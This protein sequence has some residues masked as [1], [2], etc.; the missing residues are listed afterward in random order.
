MKEFFPKTLLSISLTCA[1]FTIA[2]A[3]FMHPAKSTGQE[4]KKQNPLP[5]IR[6]VKDGWQ[7]NPETVKKVL[8]S[9]AADLWKHF[10]KRKLPPLLVHPNKGPIVL[11]KRSDKG[12]IVVRLNTGKTYWSQYA[13]QF[14]HEFCHV[15]CEYDPDPHGNDWFEESICEL[16]SLYTLRQMGKTWKTKPPYPHWKSYAKHLTQYAADRI[17]DGQLKKGETLAK[18]FKKNSEALYASATR[19]ELNL[20][21]ATQLLPMFEAEPDHWQAVGYLNKAKPKSKQ[22]FQQ[23]LSDWFRHCP[24]RHQP[25]VKKI[26]KHFEI[27]ILKPSSNKSKSANSKSKK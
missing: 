21:V 16:A 8:E 1:F 19:R 9:T 11:F 14:S 12:E 10:P 24:K 20:V 25:F 2:F 3:C 18:W 4:K 15:L 26:A 13:F 6:V 22:T 27:E 7:A 17:A 23:Y 5:E